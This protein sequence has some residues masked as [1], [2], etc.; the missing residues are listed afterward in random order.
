VAAN[1]ILPGGR[2]GRI[3]VIPLL[4][5]EYKKIYHQSIVTKKYSDDF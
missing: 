2:Q 5:L 1:N 3:K 4:D